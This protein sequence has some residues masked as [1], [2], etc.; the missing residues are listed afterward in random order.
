MAIPNLTL[1]IS[2]TVAYIAKVAPATAKIIK[3]KTAVTFPKV[4]QQRL[5]LLSIDLI[6]GAEVSFTF[7]S[8]WGVSISS[9]VVTD[10]LFKESKTV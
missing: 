7:S 2:E 8:I 5:E 3:A 6:S 4:F 10:S 9:N 1:V